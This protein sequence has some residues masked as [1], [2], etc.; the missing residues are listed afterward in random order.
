MTIQEVYE[1]I[2][3]DFDDVIKRLRKP[4]LV[5]KFTKKFL[6]DTSF[7]D[8]KKALEEE[9]LEDG[10]RAVH[11]LKGVCLNLSYTS[12]FEVAN[13]LTEMLRPGNGE[14]VMEEVF[15]TMRLLEDK[16]NAVIEGIKKLD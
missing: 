11:T 12:I 15:E 16:Y 13:K 8:L 3:G 6:A 1:E 10:F 4:E 7:N 9:K 5:E 2:G 14:P